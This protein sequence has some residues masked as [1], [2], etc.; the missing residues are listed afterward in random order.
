MWWM[1][2]ACTGTSAVDTGDSGATVPQDS[3][4]AVAPVAFTFTELWAGWDGETLGAWMLPED[5]APRPPTLQVDLFTYSALAYG[6]AAGHCTWLGELQPGEAS[7]EGEPSL[8][9]G[10][11][12]TLTTVETDCEGLDPAAW[13]GGDPVAR[14]EAA[15]IWLGFGPLQGDMTSE[16]PQELEAA[17]IDYEALAPYQLGGAVLPDA[18]GDSAPVWGSWAVV[19]AADGEGRILEEGGEPALL[20]PDEG[21]PVGVIRSLAALDFDVSALAAP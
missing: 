9:A 15:R 8:W 16:L 11:S 5:T 6:D 20:P 4:A 14:L 7:D 2:L 18:E 19:Y 1:L 17:G 21:L 12:A 13:P 10:F 3:D